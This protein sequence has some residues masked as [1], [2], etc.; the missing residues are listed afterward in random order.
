MANQINLA[1]AGSLR[2]AADYR[3]ENKAGVMIGTINEQVDWFRRQPMGRFEPLRTHRFEIRDSAGK[4]MTT[5]FAHRAVPRMRGEIRAADGTLVA[6]IRQQR[7]G[8]LFPVEVRRAGTVGLPTL[9]IVR[10]DGPGYLIEML[11]PAGIPVVEAQPTGTGE[12]RWRFR[13]LTYRLVF[14]ELADIETRILALGAF[15]ILHM[16]Y[17]AP[18]G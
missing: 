1:F 9:E 2:R 10:R 6:Q 18:R 8:K 14:A 5:S 7:I 4:V 12:R 17:V 16:V 3:L 15:P 11:D 13:F